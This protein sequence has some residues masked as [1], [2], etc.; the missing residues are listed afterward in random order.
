M[1]VMSLVMITF[2]TVMSSVQ[3]A[4]ARQE[5]RVRR[6][7]EARIAL[8]QLDRE[9]RSGNVLYDPVAE[10][11]PAGDIVPSMALRIYT[12]ADAPNRNPGNQCAQ[13]RI[14]DDTIQT[15]RW[16][17]TDPEG[18]VTA[19]WTVARNVVNRSVSPPVPA[20]SRDPA[21]T[22]GRRIINIRLVV[23][24]ADDSAGPEEFVLSITGRNTQY[25][26]SDDI[27]ATVPS[28]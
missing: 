12:Q 4:T 21:A 9:I 2:M 15:R 1:I 16:S 20:F 17:N 7:D 18:T 24:A 28:Y 27:C 11:D 23:D 10:I 3:S 14:T 25:R 22:F 19:W 5:G 6:T 13:W 26:Y 8:Q